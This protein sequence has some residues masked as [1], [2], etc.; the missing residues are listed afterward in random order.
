M[1]IGSFRWSQGQGVVRRTEWRSWLD[2]DLSV[3]RTCLHMDVADAVNVMLYASSR[4]DGQPGCAVWD[5]FRAEDADKIR[6]FLKKKY[7]QTHVFTDPIHSQLFYLDS[8]LRK[9]LFE[10]HGVVSWRIYQYPVGPRSFPCPRIH[11]SR[12]REHFIAHPFYRVK[13]F[14]F[15]LVVPI[16]YATLQTASRSRWTSSALV[17]CLSH[18]WRSQLT[19]WYQIMWLAA[20][21]S[22]RISGPKTSS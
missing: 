2:A 13:Q 14:S 4:S 3:H 20:S 6:L 15:L 22:P 18:T 9:E 1:R 21:S 11:P 12:L 16:K 7:D 19:P 8:D 17:S 10:R 5:L